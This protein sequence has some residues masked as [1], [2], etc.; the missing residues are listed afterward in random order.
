MDWIV[1]SFCT[2]LLNALKNGMAMVSMSFLDSFGINIG[3]NFTKVTTMNNP[4]SLAQVMQTYLANS[5][6]HKASTQNFFDMIF[7]LDAFK[8]TFT[9]LAITLLILMCMFALIEAGVSV[10]PMNEPLSVMGR[11]SLALIGIFFSYQLF[12]VVEYFFNEFYLAV[13]QASLRPSVIDP[14]KTKNLTGTEMAKKESIGIMH[15]YITDNSKNCFDPNYIQKYYDEVNGAKSKGG[16]TITNMG[17][18]S[19]ASQV[20]VKGDKAPDDYVDVQLFFSFVCLIALIAILLN[21]IMLLFE[22]VERYVMLGVMFYTCPLPFAALASKTTVPIFTSWVRMLFSQCLLITLNGFFLNSFIGALT[23]FGKNMAS[24][25]GTFKVDFTVYTGGMLCL[26]GWLVIGQKIDQH[27]KAL[28]LST[29]QAGG[30]LRGA[31]MGAGATAL[32]LGRTA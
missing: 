2:T 12:I 21:F 26:V 28:G 20:A 3:S 13:A 32:V 31:M 16:T 15:R 8:P 19:Q 10:R 11:F 23:R 22:I 25:D 27:L 7:S 9:A 18:S 14:P 4:M 24:V 5:N 29:A 17:G 1:R 30:G 6:A